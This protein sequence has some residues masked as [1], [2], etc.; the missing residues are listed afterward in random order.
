MQ[1]PRAARLLKWLA[2]WSHERH[3]ATLE[4]AA[5]ELL[6]ESVEPELGLFDQELAKLAAT[7]GEGG[8]VT[9]AM[10]RATVGGWRTRTAWEMLD[11]ALDGDAPAALVQLDR[12]LAGGDVP[13]ALLAQMASGLRR[14]AAAGRLIEQAEGHGRSANLRQALGEAGVKP[15]LL[16]K[17]EGQLRRLGRHRAGHL[18]R[19][20]LAADVALK[21]SSSSPPRARLV[22]EELIVRLAAPAPRPVGSPAGRRP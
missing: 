2:A 10:V 1:V 19:W 14:F 17:A 21:G 18:Y 20:L 9:A 8:K 11:A 16:G 13:I 7:A 22:L 3:G 12:L 15:F 5:A 6:A 4:P